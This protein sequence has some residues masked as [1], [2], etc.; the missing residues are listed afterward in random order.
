M[1]SLRSSFLLQVDKAVLC[2][3]L[4]LSFRFIIHMTW[5]PYIVWYRDQNVTDSFKLGT[6]NNVFLSISIHAG[7]MG[8]RSMKWSRNYSLMKAWRRG[9]SHSEGTFALTGKEPPCVQAVVWS[10]SIP[11]GMRSYSPVALRSFAPDSSCAWCPIGILVFAL[12]PPRFTIGN[13]P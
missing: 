7:G 9:S 3:P 11:L 5:Y 6:Q 12:G 2:F 4:T 1:S 10:D 13:P 8:L